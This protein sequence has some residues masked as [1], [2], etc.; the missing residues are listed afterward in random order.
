MQNVAAPGGVP[1]QPGGQNTAVLAELSHP[2]F[3][4]CPCVPRGSTGS[5]LV[6][7]SPCQCNAQH[8]LLVLNSGFDHIPSTALVHC[9]NPW[10]ADLHLL[11]QFPFPPHPNAAGKSLS[12]SGELCLH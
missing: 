12:C 5:T 11:K 4:T 6:S 8:I 7:F 2:G 1:G 10:R 3:T 9:L